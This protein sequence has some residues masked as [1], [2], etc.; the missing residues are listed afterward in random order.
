[1]SFVTSAAPANDNGVPLDLRGAPV[2]RAPRRRPQAPY[3]SAEGVIL[4]LAFA[5]RM[6][7]WQSSRVRP[8]LGAAPRH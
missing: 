7:G 1:M 3:A 8:E 4:P 5:R 2:V 6:P